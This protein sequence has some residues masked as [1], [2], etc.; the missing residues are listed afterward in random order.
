MPKKLWYVISKDTFKDDGSFDRDQ[1]Y[2]WKRYEELD[3]AI[4]KVISL[5]RADHI[6]YYCVLIPENCN[7]MVGFGFEGIFL[8]YDS[9]VNSADLEYRYWQIRE[10]LNNRFYK[11][12]G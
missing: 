2:K 3:L 7:E 12:K 1:F 10:H 4:S 8:Y 11:K 9:H 6:N 5:S